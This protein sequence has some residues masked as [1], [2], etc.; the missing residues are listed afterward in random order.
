[1]SGYYILAIVFIAL[2]VCLVVTYHITSLVLW[3]KDNAEKKKGSPDTKVKKTYYSK[4]LTYL[5]RV[6]FFKRN[7]KKFVLAIVIMAIIGAVMFGLGVGF[8]EKSNRELVKYK[9]RYSMTMMLK[10]D[11]FYK[12]CGNQIAKETVDIAEWVARVNWS[13]ERYGLFSP[14]WSLKGRV[15]LTIGG[16]EKK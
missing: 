2:A 15:H 4:G 8:E 3:C 9:A 12:Y 5:L 1:M 6:S 16:G 14:Y 7:C 10:S 13:V 11:D